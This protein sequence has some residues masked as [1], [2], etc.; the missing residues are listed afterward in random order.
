MARRQIDAYVASSASDPADRI[1][2]TRLNAFGFFDVGI[3]SLISASSAPR[4]SPTLATAGP[5]IA[6]S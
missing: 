3:S 5:D 6:E 1:S 2:S 4:L